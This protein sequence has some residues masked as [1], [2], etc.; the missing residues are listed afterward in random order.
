MLIRRQVSLDFGNDI[1]RVRILSVHVLSKLLT[2]PD[3]L[4]PAYLQLIIEEHIVRSFDMIHTLGSSVLEPDVIAAE[5]VLPDFPLAFFLLRVRLNLRHR[6]Y[7]L[8]RPLI[9]VRY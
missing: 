8:L 7:L 4:L 9:V 5:L 1:L 3:H 6:L 2:T